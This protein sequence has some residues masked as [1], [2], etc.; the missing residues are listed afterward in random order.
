M[1]RRLL[2]AYALNE[3]TWSFG[4]I[5]LAVLV[6]RRTGSALGSTAFFLCSQFA[7][8][9]VSPFL[10]ARLAHVNHRRVLPALYAA[11]GALFGLLAYIA[12]H[13]SLAPMLGVTL[14][15][16]IVA[17][18]ARAMARTPTVEVMRP[19]DLLH[20]GNAIINLVFSICFMVGPA[21]GGLVVAAGGTATSLLVNCV[22]FVLIALL[23]AVTAL[24]PPHVDEEDRGLTGVQRL[25][26]AFT[27]TRDDRAL[28]WLLILQTFGMAAF[29]ISIPVEVVFAQHTVH[30]GAGGYGAMLSGWGAGAIAGS[31]IFARYRRLPGRVM[32]ATGGLALA[33]GFAIVAVAPTIVVAV[34]GSIIGGAG[35]GT[36]GGA[37]RTALQEYTAR[38]WMNLMMSFSESLAQAAPGLGF[39]LGGVLAA[40]ADPRVAM[41]VAAFGSLAYTVATWTLLRTTLIGEPLTAEEVE[42]GR[43]RHADRMPPEHSGSLA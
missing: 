19:V 21:I 12:H 25:R 18:T 28:R 23:L 38:R 8:A 15:D 14:I 16:G 11:E 40:V 22:L 9:L 43:R 20:E 4:T 3:L 24:P 10:V 5:A 29:T 31:A 6:Y 1:F 42:S 35:N 34:I 39:V 32:M 30:A 37:I 7:P 33:I 2:A 36:S 41:A 17:L 13:F 26:A 27:H